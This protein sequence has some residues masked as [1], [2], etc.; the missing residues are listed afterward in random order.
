MIIKYFKNIGPGPLVAAAFIG[1]GTVT[2]CTLAGVNFGFTLLWA[3]ALS[4]FATVILQE[5]AA[6]L[7]I[8]SQKGLSEIIREEIKHPAVKAVALLLILSAV[9]IGNAAYEAGN[10]SGGALGMETIVGDIVL[11][12]GSLK[13]NILSVIIGSV[14]FVLL[15][16]GNYKV[17]EKAFVFL[18]ILMSIAFIT[19]AILTKPNLFEIFKSV[20]IPTAPEGSV[21][22]VIALIGTT[23]VPYNLFLHAS[24]AKTKW[25]DK[26][27]LPLAKRDTL[28]AVV[29]GGTVS[30]C[31]IIAA[32]AIQKQSIESAADLA[33]G[34]EPLFGSYAKYFLAVGLFAAG[35]TSAITAPLAAAYVTSGCLGWKADLKSKKF[36][37]VWMVIVVLGV[38]F[39]SIGFSAIEIIQ[40]A[41]VANG[42]LLPVIA[43]FLLWI[44]NKSSVL[45]A[46]KNSK[47]QN[48]FG[49]IILVITIFLGIKGILSVFNLV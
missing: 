9:V 17:L 49:L 42:M 11:E 36:K 47:L 32:S 23:V 31:I 15:Y 46:Y 13:L 43:G 4:I 37:S 41:Q 48:F 7:G 44:M 14:A 40:F 26:S 25:K 27:D 24:L 29:L 20:F 6:R 2:V 34:L 28:I 45:G 18:V 30:M 39:S 12:I 1:P 35:I 3:M 16:I 33:L 19:A 5:M 22:T 8:V 21:L 38:V 10:I